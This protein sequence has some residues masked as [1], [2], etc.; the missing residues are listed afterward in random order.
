LLIFQDSVLHPSEQT[1][2]FCDPQAGLALRVLKNLHPRTS[3]CSLF[4][5]H[6][7]G[8]AAEQQSASAPGSIFFKKIWICLQAA[9][10]SVAGQK[11]R[12]RR[13]AQKTI[14]IYNNLKSTIMA[15]LIGRITKDASV[16]NG[17]NDREFIAFTVVE[18]FPYKTK[19]GERKQQTTFCDCVYG[20]STKLAPYLTKGTIVVVN[21]RLK[22]RVF[23]D[24]DGNQKASIQ[25][26]VKEISLQG[27]GTRHNTTQSEAPAEP[28]EP[29]EGLPF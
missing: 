29:A 10:G 20:R 15:Q 2:I 3:R 16:L 1:Q 22:T 25:M 4:C 13:K 17:T 18:N 26:Q 24:R 6:Q 8:S 14:P 12:T 28:A 19:E 11:E 7:C 5:F 21:G 23:T 27:G 9:M